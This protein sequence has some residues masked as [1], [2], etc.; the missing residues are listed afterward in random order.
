MATAPGRRSGSMKPMKG[1]NIK[2]GYCENHKYFNPD[3]G[4]EGDCPKCAS[5]EVQAVDVQR[6]SDFKCSVCGSKLTPVAARASNLTN[7]IG[8]CVIGAAVVVFIVGWCLGWWFGGPNEP[9]AM[10]PPEQGQVVPINEGEEAP[11]EIIEAPVVDQPVNEVVTEPGPV[12]QETSGSK[13]VTTQTTTPSSS[14]LGGA[15]TL[16]KSGGA[17]TIKFTRPYSLDLGK[18]NGET[19]QINPGD[20]IERADVYHD[21]V[22]RAGNLKTTSGEEMYLKG[23]NV[24]LR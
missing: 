3:T 10:Y 13:E 12:P 17:Y 16:S 5:K 6:L 15:A 22:L 21:A 4:E 20:I 7:I 2:K 1:K 9:E 23:L 24:K 19:I 8:I 18:G 14:I 11:V